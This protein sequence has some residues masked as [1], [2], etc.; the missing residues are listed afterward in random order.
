MFQFIILTSKDLLGVHHLC[1]VTNSKSIKALVN[2]YHIDPEYLRFIIEA[3]SN[4]SGFE[5]FITE[6]LYETLLDIQLSD[7]ILSNEHVKGSVDYFLQM[8]LK[9]KYEE[10]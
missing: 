6:E 8:Q 5:N 2:S 10:E 1:K 3:L 7:D 9:D 4:D